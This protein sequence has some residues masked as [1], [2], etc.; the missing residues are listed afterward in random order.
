MKSRHRKRIMTE[1]VKSI[2]A[3][4]AKTDTV[5]EKGFK[6][7]E[8]CGYLHEYARA[9]GNTYFKITDKGIQGILKK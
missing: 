7:L 2:G 4:V 8:K 9:D 6:N 5:K 3:F 1:M